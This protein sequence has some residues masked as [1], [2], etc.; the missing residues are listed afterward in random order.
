[1]FRAFTADRQ[2][3]HILEATYF[4]RYVPEKQLTDLLESVV[5]LLLPNG[6]D[7]A[8]L[9]SAMHAQFVRV[10]TDIR[11]LQVDYVNPL[12]QG[13][14]SRG[15]KT[16]NIFV[17]FVDFES[18]RRTVYQTPANIPGASGGPAQRLAS[19]DLDSMAQ[20]RQLFSKPSCNTVAAVQGLHAP[21]NQM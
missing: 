10:R 7:Q 8:G 15:N 16:E 21:R 13:M 2:R 14:V 12:G 3:P 1:M 20:V 4:W 19:L 9:Q 11:P 6:F 17:E 5:R 18:E